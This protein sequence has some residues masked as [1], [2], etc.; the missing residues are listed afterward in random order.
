MPPRRRNPNPPATLNEQFMEAM[1][2][3]FQGMA[4]RAQNERPVEDRK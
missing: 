1:Y 2:A 3:A 4:T